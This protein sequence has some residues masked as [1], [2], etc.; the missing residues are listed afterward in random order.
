MTITVY[1]N[2]GN[3]VHNFSFLCAVV[4]RKEAQIDYTIVAFGNY[5][6]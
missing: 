5:L 1:S 3:I 6:L 4:L 2:Y